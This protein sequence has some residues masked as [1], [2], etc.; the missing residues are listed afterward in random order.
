MFIAKVVTVI[1]N[2]R[3]RQEKHFCVMYMTLDDIYYS[4]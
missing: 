4:D 3:I 2:F 1:I